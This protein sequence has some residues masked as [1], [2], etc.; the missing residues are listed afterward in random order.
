MCVNAE[1]V[2]VRAMRN[3]ELAEVG[4]A[5]QVGSEALLVGAELMGAATL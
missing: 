5:E 1:A 2:V 4:G 3:V